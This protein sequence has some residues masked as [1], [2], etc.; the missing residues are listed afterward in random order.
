M[1]RIKPPFT[2]LTKP[3]HTQSRGI[4]ADYLFN[5]GSGTTLHDTAPVTTWDNS[6]HGTIIG[7]TW[8]STARGAVLN[9][10]AST[11]YVDLGNNFNFG[12]G[13]T[14]NPFSFICQVKFNSLL[15]R[16]NYLISRMH[17]EYR[18]YT[19]NTLA[20]R[21]IIQLLDNSG[22][23]I[24]QGIAWSGLLTPSVWYS[25][26]FSYDGSGTSGGLILYVDGFPLPNSPIGSGPY[27]AMENVAPKCFL[28][29]IS[30]IL[31]RALDGAMESAIIFDY[32]LS[33]EEFFDFH[34]NPYLRYRRAFS[35]YMGNALITAAGRISRY[36]DLSGLGG[37]GQMTWDPLG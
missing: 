3:G 27:I 35:P 33:P 12:N 23:S 22:G 19:E 1:S 5:R 18:F 26:G 32:E 17:N 13:T 16:E 36:H 37:Q 30:T 28:G 11:D 24:G 34:L 21:F 20:R 14:D 7:P 2:A 6:I 25:L 4:V 15:S 8:I 9:W 10:G 29:R 31:S